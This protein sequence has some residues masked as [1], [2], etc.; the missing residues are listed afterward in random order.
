MGLENKVD[1][2][3]PVIN[4]LQEN[5]VPFG[6][7]IVNPVALT[8]SDQHQGVPKRMEM[9]ACLI[10]VKPPFNGEGIRPVAQFE[11]HDKF[12]RRGSMLMPYDEWIGPVGSVFRT[13]L[14]NFERITV[15][16]YLEILPLAIDFKAGD[17]GRP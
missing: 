10:L 2:V 16:E 11:L 3:D 5:E 12:G 13:D 9:I 7:V 6:A 15:R 8:P 4:P 17:S 1:I 14:H